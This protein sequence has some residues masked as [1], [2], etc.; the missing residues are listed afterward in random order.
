MFTLALLSKQ[1]NDV[2]R[3]IIGSSITKIKLKCLMY[4]NH[5]ILYSGFVGNG[6]ASYTTFI[7]HNVKGNRDSKSKK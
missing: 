5:I 3:Q 1:L 7:T 4:V 2:G 6:T